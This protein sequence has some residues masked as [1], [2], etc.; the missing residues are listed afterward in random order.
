MNF[1]RLQEK[2]LHIFT[3]SKALSEA[4]LPYGEIFNAVS[5]ERYRFKPYPVRLFS[6]YA[7]FFVLF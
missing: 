3:L 2:L 6:P 1:S 4:I 7:P 5:A